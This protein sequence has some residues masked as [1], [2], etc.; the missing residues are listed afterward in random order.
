M[1]PQFRTPTLRIEARRV[2]RQ[3]SGLQTHA[4]KLKPWVDLPGDKTFDRIDSSLDLNLI[5]S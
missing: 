4:P 2:G 1:M 3:E 5:I